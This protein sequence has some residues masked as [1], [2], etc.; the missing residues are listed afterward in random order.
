MTNCVV[1]TSPFC[2]PLVPPVVVAAAVGIPAAVASVVVVA[3]AVI[4]DGARQHS[5]LLTGPRL[6]R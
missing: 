2:L 4:M 3:A 1:N 5:R 6:C